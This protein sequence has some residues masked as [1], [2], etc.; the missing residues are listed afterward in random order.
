MERYVVF[1]VNR[2]VHTYNDLNDAISCAKKMRKSYSFVDVIDSETG[3]VIYT[4]CY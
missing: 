3:K 4:W 2:F 1:Y